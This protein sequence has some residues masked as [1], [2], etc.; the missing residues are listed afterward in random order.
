M[1]SGNIS[2]RFNID[3]CVCIVFKAYR[4]RTQRM[5][6]LMMLKNRQFVISL[7]LLLTTGLYVHA[8]KY[9]R[10]ISTERVQLEQF[11]EQFGDWHITEHGQLSQQV[12][13]VLKSDQQIMRKYVNSHGDYVWLFLAYFRDQKYGEQIHSPRHCLPGGGWSIVNNG[14]I[15][16]KNPVSFEANRLAIQQNDQKEIM[17]YWFWTRNGIIRS[18]FR[19]KFDLAINSLLRR[20]TDAAFVRL[21]VDNS[22]NA[23]EVIADFLSALFP[24]LQSTLPFEK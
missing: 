24:E 1:N 8:V 2:V 20:P 13:D 17:S 12:L 14:K 16:F 6:I 22:E 3:F 15:K 10:V 4:K 7:I 11:P 23:D 19:L 18:E 21:N 9:S 5:K